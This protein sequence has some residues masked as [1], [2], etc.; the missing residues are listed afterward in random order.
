VQTPRQKKKKSGNDTLKQWVAVEGE[1]LA[2]DTRVLGAGKTHKM[3]LH[4]KGT[5]PRKKKSKNW[6]RS[7]GARERKEGHTNFYKC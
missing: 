7:Y 3:S 1:P 2:S 4:P 5:E 6:C